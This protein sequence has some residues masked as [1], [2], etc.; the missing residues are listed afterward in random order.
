MKA[1]GSFFLTLGLLF[2]AAV[3]APAVRAAALSEKL[4]LLQEKSAELY[5]AGSYREALQTG[6]QALALTIK[7]F[8]PDS[9][10]VSIQ[11]YGVGYA[12]E[13][14]G[15]FDQAE[16][17]YSQSVHIREIV[18]GPD[19]AGVAAGLERLGHVVLK[20]NRPAE[21]EALFM[22]ELKIWND[23]LG[24]HAIAAG[25]YSGLGAVHLTLRDFPAALANYR[26][27]VQQLTSETAAEAL[28]RSVIE[29]GIKEHREIFVGLAQ[30]AWGLRQQPGADQAALMDETFAAGQRAWATSAA[31]ALAKMTARLSAGETD[32]GRAIRDLEMH[33]RRILA[34]NRLDVKAL[35]AWGKVQQ[36][37][38]SYR[39]TLE[40]F[41]AT[42][43]AR[44]RDNAPVLKR[45]KELIERLQDELKRCPAGA[46]NNGCETSE[47][48][49]TAISKELN[50]LS[51]QAAQAAREINQL[52]QRLVAAERQ[53]PGYAE[54]NSTRTARLAESGRLE[55]EL[56][57]LRAGIVRR[58]PDYL[59]LAEPVPLTVD[60]TQKLL[61][62]DEAL[63]AVLTGPQTS[64]VWAVTRDRADWVVVSAGEAAL[65]EEVRALRRGLEPQ[66]DGIPESFDISRAYNL[67][68]LLLD[69]FSPMLSGKR[70]LLL[71][72]TGPLSSLPFQ[73]LVTEAPRSGLT[74]AEALK[75]AKWLI[76]R[77]ALSVLPSVQS[78]SALRN[79]AA[80]GVAVKP[81]FGIGDPT[82]GDS[83]PAAGNGRGGGDRQLS[84]ATLYRNGAAD[85]RLLQTLA[86]LPE[87]A[88]E[89][90]TVARTL[91]ASEENIIVGDEATKARLKVTPLKDYRILHFA[92]HGLVAGDLS[93]LREPALVLT[94]PPH[95][96]KADD[97]LLTASEVATLQLNADWAVLSACNTASGRR[98]GADALSGLARA[99]FFAGARA[100]LVSH[101]AVNS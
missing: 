35:A 12:A 14:A 29:A 65:A 10:Q 63:V 47:S 66:A 2:A 64:L 89:L 52:S 81:Y 75:Q 38:L 60:E 77:H 44:S 3:S 13:A 26:K 25:A 80:S 17:Q 61:G 57:V 23:L 86:P 43:I 90:R 5:Q 55:R 76:R 62:E 74:G 93:G 71:V 51:A 8:G 31:S 49:R 33:N 85:V 95:S 45:Q 9:E 48:K 37:D 34:L 15:D 83:P 67:Y 4:K 53:L 88:D 18:Y 78:L 91:G 24:E 99:F 73:V 1:L 96:V 54:F 59:S 68:A 58:F 40:V 72:P 97:A 46:R 19:S 50:A 87:T 6:Q 27:A 32:R 20:L 69:R 39:E 98:V 22:R 82:F 16:R 92:T 79:F 36:A 41:R 94:L 70:H 28:A 84:L 11:T 42:S 7:E 100:L 101:W 30:A 21:A 56:T